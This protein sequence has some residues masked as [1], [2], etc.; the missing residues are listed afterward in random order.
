MFK[1]E[2]LQKLFDDSKSP[3]IGF[4]GACHDCGKPVCIDIDQDQSGGVSVAGGAVYHPAT[5][6]TEEDKTFFLKCDACFE[7]NPTLKKFQ[8]CSV[9]SRVVGYLRPVSDWNEG[10]QSEYAMRKTFDITK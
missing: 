4:K 8:P 5:G 6:F 9:Y 10:K 2:D 3:K 1:V 7:V